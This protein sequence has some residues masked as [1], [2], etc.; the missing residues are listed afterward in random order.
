MTG[1]RRR[2]IFSAF[3]YG[4]APWW[5]HEE[6]PHYDGGY[7]A[8]LLLNVR[9][10]LRW[11][12]HRETEED[13]AF[14]IDV[15][16]AEAGPFTR[17]WVTSSPSPWLVAESVDEIRRT[18]VYGERAGVKFVALTPLRGPQRRVAIWHIV[19]VDDP[20]K[21]FVA[22]CEQRSSAA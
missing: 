5:L 1:I 17:V 3:V 12:T 11:L 14:E 7:L 16:G 18:I 15:N 9:Y 21:S 19:A 22:S 20:A 2:A 6:K 13:L 8:H 10:G 4:L